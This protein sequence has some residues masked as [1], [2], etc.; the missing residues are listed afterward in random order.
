MPKLDDNP[1]LAA[2][3]LPRFAAIEARH[4]KPAIEHVLGTER[5]NLERLAA[6]EA[7]SLD[8]LRDVEALHERIHDVW[9]PVYH[10]NSVASNPK[11]RKAFNECLIMVTEFETELGQNERL[12][13]CFEKLAAKVTSGPEGE[14]IRKGLRDFKLGGVALEG[15]AK[16]A[17]RDVSMQLAA[18]QAEFEQNLM[19]ATDAFSHHVTDA[20]ALAG[21]PET[22]RDRAAQ[23][24]ADEGLDGWLLKL[25]PPTYM[26]VI[27]HADSDALRERYYRA[28]VTRASDIGDPQWDNNPLIE[29]ILRLRQRSAELLGFE[30]FAELSLATKMAE[31]PAR[32]LEFLE[33]LASRSRQVAYA[34]LDSLR[35]LAGHELE[36]WDVFY[37]AE[38]LKAERFIGDEELRAYFPLPHVLSGMFSL[39]ERLFGIRLTEV[40]G[41]ELW[42]GTA[43]AYRITNTDGSPVGMLLTDLYAR[44]NKRGGAWMD[45][46]ANRSR[47]GP[48]S[49]DPIAYLVCNFAPPSQ[50]KPS[51]LTHRD[52]VTLFHEFGH[53]LHHLLTEI[54]YPSIAGI[55][56][57]AWDAIELPSQFFEN[58]AWSPDVLRAISCH[59]DSSDALPDDKIGILTE[60]RTFLAGHY[61]ARQVEYAL[62]DFRLHVRSEPASRDEVQAVIDAV[63]DEIG[64][65][66]I[67]PTPPFNRFQCTFSHIFGGGYAA[68]YYSYKWAEVLAADAFAAFE[69]TDTFDPATAERFRSEILAVGGSRPAMDSFVAFRGRPP[70]L[71][72]L[73]RQAGIAA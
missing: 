34:D 42:H 39:A 14:L 40:E 12:F 66:E 68:G 71:E 60:S 26:A 13:R 38:K 62:I 21:I 49:R 43:Q 37:Y 20:A 33:D 65:T 59:R 52:V 55:N 25:D 45:S 6:T 8:W 11:L 48:R 70:E 7:P 72:P 54:D 15:E 32:V 23:L 36:A 4:I 31:S 5:R 50:D 73:L 44:P 56:G 51:Y 28:W 19:D 67:V 9:G 61:M 63:R 2:E 46:C 41:T 30:N 1:L 47:L 57:V 18:K 22:V 3:A 24:A 53:T 69:E 64:L 16:Q 17:F 29:E 58:Y 35:T 10:L 27:S